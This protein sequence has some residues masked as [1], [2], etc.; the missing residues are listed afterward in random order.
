MSENP[1]APPVEIKEVTLTGDPISNIKAGPPTQ[2][3]ESGRDKVRAVLAVGL[4]ALFSLI[5]V[6]GF[7]LVFAPPESLASS[8]RDLQARTVYVQTMLGTVAGV[9]GAAT[10]FYFATSKPNKA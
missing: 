9:F 3:L 4:L 10:G 1:T 6:L 7:V 8:D 5:V 2:D